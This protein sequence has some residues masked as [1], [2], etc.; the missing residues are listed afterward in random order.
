MHTIQRAIGWLLIAFCGAVA[1][2]AHAGGVFDSV[3]GNV[4]LVAPDGSKSTAQ[5]Y[6]DI[7]V[8]S[9]INTGDGAQAVIRFDDGG[10]VVLDHNSQFRVVDYRYDAKKPAE[11][12]SVFDFLKGAARFVTGLIARTEYANYSL[13]TQVATIGVRGTDFDLATGSLYISVNSGAV[14]ATNASG[15][16]GFGAKQLGFIQNAGTLPTAVSSLPGGVSSAFAR[17]NAIPLPAGTLAAAPGAESAAAP[18][19]GEAAGSAGGISGTTAAAIGL[20]VVGATAL[21]GIHS[22]S[23]TTHH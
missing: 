23:T 1:G 7:P 6:G 2:I 11:G 10:A 17:I 5:R 22:S 18:G 20:G 14:T 21:G 19:A 4:T 12:R 13:R 3:T 15:T 8:G 9:T 16:V